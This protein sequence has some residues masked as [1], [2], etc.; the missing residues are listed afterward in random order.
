[1]AGN[2][3]P[4][5]KLENEDFALPNYEAMAKGSRCEEAAPTSRSQDSSSRIVTHS[6]YAKHGK[7]SEEAASEPSLPPI[8]VDIK[9][10]ATT[11]GEDEHLRRIE[12]KHKI[13]LKEGKTPPFGPLY[14]L[15]TKELEVLR[16]YLLD[17]QAKGWIGRSS[18]PAEAS[19]L[20]VPKKGEILRLCV[21][22]RG[23]NRIIRKKRAT[24]PL[25]NEIFDRL[26]LAKIYSKLNL[27]N[28]YHRIRIREGDEWKTAFR[29]RYG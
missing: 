8:Y 1:M 22:Y 14:P 7:P 3:E 19:I 27:K 17:A 20:F 4:S 26:T 28:A 29:T 18:S 10:I 11:E 5:G 13:E 25:I 9:D 21:N 2:R 24:L 23:L 6:R 12:A 15:S 16:T